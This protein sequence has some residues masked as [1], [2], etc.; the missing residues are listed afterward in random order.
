MN[1]VEEQIAAGLCYPPIMRSFALRTG[2]WS[3]QC[4]AH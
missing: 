2:D 1:H 4:R 3:F